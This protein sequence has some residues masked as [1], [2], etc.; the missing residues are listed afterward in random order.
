[1]EEV[2][3][4][5]DFSLSWPPGQTEQSVEKGLGKRGDQEPDE[6][7]SRDPVWRETS[8]IQTSLQHSTGPGLYGRV[9]RQKPLLCERLRKARLEFA[10][11]RLS[12]CEKP[13]SLVLWNQDWTFWPQL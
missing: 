13:D 5:Q 6:L 1:M 10:P 4:N 9:A 11:K 8:K 12:D 3:N 2:W 7:S